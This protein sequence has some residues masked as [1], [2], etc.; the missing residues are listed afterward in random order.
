[1]NVV[2]INQ[3][4]VGGGGAAIAAY[5]LHSE[6][7]RI[8]ILSRLVVGDSKLR[9]PDTR[10]I[11]RGPRVFKRYR[12]RLNR[13]FGKLG[14]NYVNIPSTF[15][16]RFLPELRNADVVNFHNIHSGYFNYLA[17][18]FL[19]GGRPVVFTLHDMWALTGHCAYSFD[20]TRWKEGCGQCMYK[21][22]YPRIDLDLTRIE[23]KLKNRSFDRGNVHFVTP[24]QW[25]A[26]CVKQ[27]FSSFGSVTQIP[28][29]LDLDVY[30]DT[31]RD[32][33]RSRL[34]IDTPG[35]LLMFVANNLDDQRKGGE[36]L[37]NALRDLPRESR[38]NISLLVFGKTDRDLEAETGLK[39]FNLGYLEG[40]STKSLAYSAADCFVMPSTAD[41]APVVIQEALACGTP[42]VGFDVGGIGEM[43]LDG[44]TGI[45]VREL[46]SE[47]L[48]KGIETISSRRD[49]QKEASAK[50]REF[51]VRKYCI[52]Q[53]AARYRE[54]YEQIL[55]DVRH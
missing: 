27:R 39:V 42:I 36:I 52:T 31:D 23:W 45:L 54:L 10:R 55:G 13:L 21:H 38:R 49:F 3:S 26:E 16:L 33:A 4:D 12:Q 30:K 14:L 6:L 18:Q 15:A 24:S 29:G 46:T 32:E 25:L 5:R 48:S 41:N 34:G 17:F 2:H 8:G 35:F 20:C 53:S 7:T 51:A 43:I 11:I 47:A 37:S 19:T 1:M 28:N 9:E 40:D 22:T 50:C 44:E